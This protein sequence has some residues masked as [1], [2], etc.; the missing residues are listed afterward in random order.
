MSDMSISNN[1]RSTYSIYSQ[2]AVRKNPKAERRDAV[3]FCGCVS[4]DSEEKAIMD[5]LYMY[6]C[7]PTGDKATDKAKLRRIEYEKAKQDNYVSN[8]YL[9]VSAGECERI[10][11][12]KKENRKIAN[13]EKVPKKQD[14]RLGDKLR[15]E[16]IYL[17]IQMKQKRDAASGSSSGRVEAKHAA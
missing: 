5:R 8:K 12:R 9:T 6:G 2:S 16:Q 13:P 11:E 7:V 14:E 15:G 4:V 3:S 10:Q 1:Y 17:A